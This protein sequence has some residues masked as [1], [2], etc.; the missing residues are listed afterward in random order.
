VALKIGVGQNRVIEDWETNWMT[1]QIEEKGNYDLSFEVY[2]AGETNQKLEL[3]VMAGGADLPDVAL[4]DFKHGVLVKYGQAG[5][6]IPTNVYYQ[7][8]AHYYNLA[9]GG[10]DIDI[11]KY[12]TSYDGNIWGMFSHFVGLTNDYA[13]GWVMIYEPWL[14]KLGLK[15]PET[16]GEFT[17][18]LRAFRDRDPNGNGKKDEIP[19][20]AYKDTVNTNMLRSLMNPFIY[21]QTDFWMLNNNKLDVSFNKP[22]YR[23]GLR[24][25][26]S[27]LDERL[28]SPL[29]FTQDRAQ[30]TAQI[31]PDPA[32]VGVFAFI[33]SS[34]LP[35]TDPKRQEYIIQVPLQGPGGRQI[36]RE[37]T[38]PRMRMIITKNCKTPESAFVMGDFLYSEDMSVANRWG[39]KGVDWVEPAPGETSV[40]ADAG[41]PPT[42]KAISPWGVIQNKWWASNG[43]YLTPQKWP[44]GLVATPSDHTVALGRSIGPVLQYV[45]KNPVF[46]IIY[47]AEEQE[48]IDELHSTILTY[49][50]ESFARFV[51]GDLSVDTGWN[52]YVAEFDRM[53]LPDV[54]RVT[55]SAWD[56]MNK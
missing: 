46:G 24:Y 14:K 7:N 34:N 16:I 47:N 48:I 9:K 40:F 22:Q 18:T 32:T 11:L 4:G 30:M 45:N 1:R 37:P 6:I 3:I 28:I 43:P 41:W 44:N 31:T 20:A 15:M 42:L 26:K 33:S 21:T 53:G 10:F 56:R 8:S 39:E 52:S 25:I 49:V 51:M 54:I 19:F 2:P 23:E 5:M 13:N 55:Q 50:H 29:S 35:T 12:V 17:N 36:P 38:L 27:L